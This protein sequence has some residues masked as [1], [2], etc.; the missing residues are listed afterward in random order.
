[1]LR[2]YECRVKSNLQHEF[3]FGKSL[4][5][6][7]GGKKSSFHLQLVGVF[8]LLL[9]E[10]LKTDKTRSEGKKRDDGENQNK[11]NF[12]FGSCCCHVFLLIDISVCFS[13]RVKSASTDLEF[14]DL[15]LCGGK[16]AS[17]EEEVEARQT[18]SAFGLINKS[19]RQAASKA[20]SWL[21]DFASAFITSRET[22]KKRCRN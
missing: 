6:S 2:V 15:R 3:E 10:S 1:V 17:D 11:R 12:P 7:R 22:E 19:I 8:L 16:E 20:S 4:K 13:L 9:F 21:Q 18:N 14:R 5:A